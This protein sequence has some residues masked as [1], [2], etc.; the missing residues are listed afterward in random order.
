MPAMIVV[1]GHESRDQALRF[2][3]TTELKA[4]TNQHH[5]LYSQ[6]TQKSFHT[7]YINQTTNITLG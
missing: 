7:S 6:H 5:L 2:Q 1:D 4:P 3:L